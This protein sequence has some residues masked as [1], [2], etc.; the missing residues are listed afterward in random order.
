[1]TTINQEEQVL[2]NLR[3]I[4]R[5]TDLYSRKLSKEFGHL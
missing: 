2:I 3:Q 5:A 4:I 1:M